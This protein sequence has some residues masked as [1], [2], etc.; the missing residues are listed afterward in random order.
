MW[1]V[2]KYLHSLL[3]SLSLP[4]YHQHPLWYAKNCH[5]WF[6]SPIC[7]HQK[8]CNHFKS[9]FYQL[10]SNFNQLPIFSFADAHFLQDPLFG[11]WI[12]LLPPPPSFLIILHLPIYLPHSVLPPLA[13]HCLSSPPHSSLLLGFAS[14][15]PPL[16][17]FASPCLPPLVFTSH[18][19][20]PAQFCLPPPAT[21]PYLSPMFLIIHFYLPPPIFACCLYY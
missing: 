2:W 17:G 21:S 16:L 4:H 20:P 9:V 11:E 15:Y 1:L 5:R 19:P 18:Y 10:T 6:S 12:P 13:S 8:V 3:P 7:G 14:P